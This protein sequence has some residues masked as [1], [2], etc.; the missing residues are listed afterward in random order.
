MEIWEDSGWWFV[1]YKGEIH[2]P[3][4]TKTAIE[5]A[6]DEYYNGSGYDLGGEG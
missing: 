5:E 2:G 1:D 4:V 6:L 3:F